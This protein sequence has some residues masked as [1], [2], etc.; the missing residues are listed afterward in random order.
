MSK[1]GDTVCPNDTEAVVLIG[2]KTEG[3]SVVPSGSHIDDI[4]YGLS[5]TGDSNAPEVSFKVNN[6]F[7]VPVDM[8]VEYEQKVGSHG[9]K[10]PACAKDTELGHCKVDAL[11]IT[12]AC[13]NPLNEIPFAIFSVYFVSTDACFGVGTTSSPPFECCA[14]EADTLN[15]PF[16][17]YTFKIMCECPVTQRRLG[18]D[19]LRGRK[20]PF[21]DSL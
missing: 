17:K 14:Q 20:N 2:T 19:F 9:A 18:L 10:D 4:I 15:D 7:S 1:T 3:G 21:H 13:M 8:Y 5:F 16:V 11:E 12:A 6:P